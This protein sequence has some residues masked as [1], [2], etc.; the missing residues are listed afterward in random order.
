MPNDTIFF[1]R[2]ALIEL[3]LGPAANNEHILARYKGDPRNWHQGT[4]GSKDDLGG[5]IDGT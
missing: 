4:I 2:K 3:T 5:R 1:S